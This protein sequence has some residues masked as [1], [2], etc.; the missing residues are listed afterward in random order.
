MKSTPSSLEQPTGF[1]DP[2][3]LA[4]PVWTILHIALLLDVR[5]ASL[6]SVVNLPGFPSPL[7]NQKRNRRWWAE[8]V[9]AFFIQR[10][11]SQPELPVPQKINRAQSPKSM[12][13]K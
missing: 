12:R 9:R 5:P 8:D 3:S 10:S 13:L 4:D 1:K 6:L 11:Q 2:V 7:I